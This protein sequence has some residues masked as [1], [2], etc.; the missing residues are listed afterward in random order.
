MA[1]AIAKRNQHFS[2]NFTHQN[3]RINSHSSVNGF[4][5]VILHFSPPSFMSL[6]KSPSNFE[7]FVKKDMIFLEKCG[8]L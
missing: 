1:I 8:I 2:V 5:L 4:S 7:F 3:R 6:L